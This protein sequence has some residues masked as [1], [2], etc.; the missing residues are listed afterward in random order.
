M[1][2]EFLSPLFLGAYG[3]NDEVLEKLVVEFLR[4]HV[5]WRRNFHPDDIP[6]VST[7]SQYS[8]Q[9]LDFVA[10]MKQELH[11]LS[12]KL[13]RSVP[14]F[15]PRYLGHM[16]S[17]LLL[18]G[19]IAQL[20]TTLY[21]PNNIS[22]E[23][24][25]VTVDMELSVGL[26]LARMLGFSAEET[27]PEGAFGHLTSG[28]T[29][30]NYESLWVAR[31]L[32]FYPLA[33][34]AA[35][36]RTGFAFEGVG[37]EGK[38]IAEYSDWELFNLSADEIV[39]LRQ[40]CLAQLKNGLT[41]E[42]ADAVRIAI[43]GE[44][45]EALG[46]AEFFHKRPGLHSPVVMVPVTAH[47]SWE[48]AMKLLGLGSHQLIAIPCKDMRLDPDALDAQIRHCAHH[49]IPILAV[50]GVLGSTEFG[51]LD[52]LHQIIAI[53]ERW[54]AEGVHFQVHV[55]AAWG[56]YLVSAFREPDGS[57]A[58]RQAVAEGHRYFPSER[59]HATMA[60]LA[61]VDSVTIDPHKLGYLPYGAGAYVCRDRRWMDF[62]SQTAAYVFDPTRYSAKSFRDKFKG[63]G[64]FILEG[65]KA[66][67]AAA[68]A[69]VT[70]RVI[71]LDRSGFGRIVDETVV[72]T[73][74]L[75]DAVAGLQKRLAGKARVAI[76][77]E[78]D[79][80]LICLAINPVGNFSAVR[81]NRFM[82]AV[83]E[84]LAV[85]TNR[86]VQSK[87]F[88]GSYTSVPRAILSDAEATRL[89]TEL[90]LASETWALSPRDPLVQ[91]DALFILR[92]TLMN[93]WL[94]EGDVAEAY[95]DY[96]AKCVL[97]ELEDSEEFQY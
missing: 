45:V 75:H 94:A 15:H 86:P 55:D 46:L 71:P 56:G 49:G 72:A 59:V 22:Y 57:L 28:G 34:K 61:Q 31:S 17:D 66:G 40:N 84:H 7:A 74:R 96:L 23:A 12:A 90:G 82:R 51:T 19:L 20:V 80:N 25:P 67:A 79:C 4:D 87:E 92:H 43:A 44:R 16:A 62:V 97:A 21:N 91:A 83:F 95:L 35:S 58:P 18:P 63:L 13:K 36:E 33:L 6:R 2:R 11:G 85:D 5:Y 30:A 42:G 76:P 78:P 1:D 41:A 48:K 88:F 70:H 68:A 54:A 53:R 73:E 52:P 47:Y 26:Q 60:A 38:A 65:S 39:A 3:E 93:P 64:Q 24:A 50:V 69:Y 37:P 9:Y 29:V 8:P 89:C 14:F 81:A 27:D 10:R 77:F 32:R